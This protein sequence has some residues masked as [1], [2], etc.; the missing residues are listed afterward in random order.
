[1][2]KQPE[3]KLKKDTP[4][5]LFHS[6]FQETDLY[7]QAREGAYKA[8]ASKQLKFN[9]EEQVLYDEEEQE[10]YVIENIDP[11]QST[12]DRLIPD[13]KLRELKLQQQFPDQ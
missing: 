10:V 6:K 5:A 12:V 3:R 11:K 7:Q 2:S 4:V 9:E 8:E 1:M 13:K